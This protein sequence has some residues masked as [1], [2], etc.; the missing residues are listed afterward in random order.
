MKRGVTG[1]GG[2]VLL[3]GAPSH[4][5]PLSGVRSCIWEI[6]VITL[7]AKNHEGADWG[8]TWGTRALDL[9]QPSSRQGLQPRLWCRLGG[10]V[11]SGARPAPPLSW[12]AHLLQR[13][14]P[15][16]RPRARLRALQPAGAL[17]V[18]AGRHLCLLR[19][20]AAPPGPGRGAPR[21]RGQR[22]AGAPLG[23]WGAPPGWSGGWH[24]WGREHLQGSE[25][26]SGGI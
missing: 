4:S 6:G 10:R 23:R 9:W 18:A 11:C 22:P 20:H 5:L 17:P 1:V 8:G 2:Q 24:S 14:L 26:G 7:P 25:R 3:P 21:A 13:G 16:S 12:A 19:G 15:Q